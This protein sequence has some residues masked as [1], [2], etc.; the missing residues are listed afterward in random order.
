MFIRNNFF[1]FDIRNIELNKQTFLKNLDVIYYCFSHS[2]FVILFVNFIND[3]TL[4][5]NFE[6]NFRL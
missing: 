3:K 1:M 4:C 6:I 2:Y 5:E